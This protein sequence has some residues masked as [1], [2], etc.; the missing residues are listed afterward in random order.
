SKIAS[1]PLEEQE[2]IAA[3]INGIPNANAVAAVV[4]EYVAVADGRRHIKARDALASLVRALQKGNADLQGRL[5][6]IRPSAA[7]NCLKTLWQSAKMLGILIELA[8]RYK[9][10][11]DNL[12]KLKARLDTRSNRRRAKLPAG[13]TG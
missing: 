6:E 1:Q 9:P 5:T 3:K 10:R 13:L 4:S 7:A 12:A 8:G 11:P 2:A